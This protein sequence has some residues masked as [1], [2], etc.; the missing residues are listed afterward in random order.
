M[1]CLVQGNNSY[2]I[3]VPYNAKIENNIVKKN[4]SHGI[5]GLEKCYIAGNTSVNNGGDGIQV[6]SESMILNNTCS[7][8]QL[9]GIACYN[10]TTNANRNYVEGNHV[11]TNG[12]AGILLFGCQNVMIKNTAIDNVFLN[13]QVLNPTQ[14]VGTENR[15]GGQFTGTDLGSAGPFSNFSY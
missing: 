2:G 10:A 4:L 15:D 1:N 3:F 9:G 13:Y 8:N 7:F 12:A 6:G 5:A 11:V 14:C